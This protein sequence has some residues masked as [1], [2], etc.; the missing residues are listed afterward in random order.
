MPYAWSSRDR[1]CPMRM[2]PLDWSYPKYETV[3]YHRPRLR[4]MTRLEIGPRLRVQEIPFNSDY[5]P[6]R[7]GEWPVFRYG[8]RKRIS[9]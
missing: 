5:P 7:L 9:Q 4:K 3:K 2:V 6:G 8:R 1:L